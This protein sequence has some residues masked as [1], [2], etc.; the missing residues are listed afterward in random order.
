MYSFKFKV[1]LKKIFK[2][3][4]ER[5]E[6]RRDRML[7]LQ[8]ALKVLRSWGMWMA[9]WAYRSPQMTES[10]GKLVFVHGSEIKGRCVLPS[11]P[12]RRWTWA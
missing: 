2:G 8:S 6:G 4:G 11:L 3:G 9:W 1:V 10:K 5:R 12:L 7:A